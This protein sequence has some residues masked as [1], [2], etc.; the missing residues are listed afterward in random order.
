MTSTASSA[1]TTLRLNSADG[2]RQQ[3]AEQQ[4]AAGNGLCHIASPSLEIAV[5]VP[6]E[7]LESVE[8][9]GSPLNL[10][11]PEEDPVPRKIAGT[12]CSSSKDAK[13]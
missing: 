2:Y 12:T 8:P 11:N 5:S 9:L 6:G 10:I 13:E 1:S 4:T 7:A 3:A